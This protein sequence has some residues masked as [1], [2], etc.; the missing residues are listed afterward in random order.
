MYLDQVLPDRNS[1]HQLQQSDKDEPF[2]AP[3]GI[4]THVLHLAPDGCILPHV[5]NVDASGGMIL[6]VSLGAERILRLEEASEGQEGKTGNKG[7]EVLLKSGS[8]YVQK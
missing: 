4:I 8:V 6:G 1:A 3:L 2:A 7:W 5:D